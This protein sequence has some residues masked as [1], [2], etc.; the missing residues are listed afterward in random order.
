MLENRH[1]QVQNVIL[2]KKLSIDL[3]IDSNHLKTIDSTHRYFLHV[4][5]VLRKGTEP[6][7][8]FLTFLQ[9]S[10]VN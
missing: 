7:R 9:N 1:K 6:S 4:W 8:I 5:S 3:F 10:H 2:E